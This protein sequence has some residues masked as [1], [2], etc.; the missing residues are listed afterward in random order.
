MKGTAVIH[1]TFNNRT[2]I[3]SGIFKKVKTIRQH[4]SALVSYFSFGQQYSM[5]S[6]YAHVY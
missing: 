3:F 1:P 2:H 4:L 6:T 5:Y